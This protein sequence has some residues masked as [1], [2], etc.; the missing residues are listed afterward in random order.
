MGLSSGHLVS[1]SILR[2]LASRQL[3][4][5]LKDANEVAEDVRA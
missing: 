4:E 5:L 3:N 1:L 2:T